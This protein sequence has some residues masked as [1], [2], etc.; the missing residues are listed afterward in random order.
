MST[1]P[2]PDPK[3]AERPGL[4]SFRVSFNELFANGAKAALVHWI[5]ICRFAMFNLT[6][7]GGAI[8][9]A[10]AGTDWATCSPQTRFMICVGV[11]ISWA[12][13]V[14]SFLDKSLQRMAEGKSPLPTGA[15]GTPFK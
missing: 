13:N 15:S 10:L 5:I 12:G 3:P 8:L 2:K 7:I 6:T 9:T 14:G 11:I 1:D 4:K